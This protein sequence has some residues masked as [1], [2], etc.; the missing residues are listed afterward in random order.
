[1]IDLELAARLES[2]KARTGLSIA[3]QVRQAIRY[4]LES[5][6]WSVTQPRRPTRGDVL[7]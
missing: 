5:R 2:T 4:W 3:E 7:D 6:E 1:M